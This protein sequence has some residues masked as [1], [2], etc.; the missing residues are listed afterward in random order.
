MHGWEAVCGSSILWHSPALPPPFSACQV[1]DPACRDFLKRAGGP[2]CG[3]GKGGP[4][5]GDRVATFILCEPFGAYTL[6][7][8]LA[9]LLPTDSLCA[10]GEH[11]ATLPPGAAARCDPPTHPPS[12]CPADLKSPTKGGQTAFPDAEATKQAMGDEHRPGNSP[13]SDWYCHD[14]RVLAAAPPAGTGVLFW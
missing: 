6:A 3:P 4:T 12:H 13:N 2:E 14:E 7:A 9:L 1:A 11:A 10:G 5:C 8:W